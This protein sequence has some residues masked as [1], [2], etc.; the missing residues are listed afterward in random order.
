[1]KLKN[2]ILIGLT[3][4]MFFSACVKDEIYNGPATIDKVSIMPEA[5]KST[6]DVTVNAQITDLKGI[7]SATLYYR[8]SPSATFLPVT[9][10]SGAGFMFS[11]TIP[12]SPLNTKIEYYI[13]VKNNGGF[14]TVSPSNA[15]AK[16]AS[17]TVGVSSAVKIFINE[18][19]SD[20]T[21]DATDPDWVEIY[22]GSDIAVDLSGYAF[23]DEG[24]KS[25]AGAKPKR[26]LNSGTIIPA[27]G[28]LVLKTENTAGEYAVEF[29]LGS[30]GDAVYLENTT[31][32]VVS[33]LDFSSISLVGKKS[34]GRQPDGST[35]F[36]IFT[37]PTK[38]T[39]N[40]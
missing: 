6:D 36:V 3:P 4:L 40:N 8:I 38:G 17:Y 23:Y 22:N 24:I 34:Y 37:T 28:F 25:S 26:I 27:K 16:L 19:F 35:N 14:T 9:M 11:G 29:G 12:A 10:K 13:E 18:A 39:S 20:G 15:P 30:S 33:S 2:F 31:G 5:P 7:T 32:I 1:M 21:K